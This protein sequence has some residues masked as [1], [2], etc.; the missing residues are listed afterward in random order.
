MSHV[1]R[2]DRLRAAFEPAGVDALVVSQP[3]SRY[4]LSGYA[5]HDLPPRDSAGYLIVTRDKTLLLTDPRT[6]EQA[7][8]E[9]P[10][11][12]IITYSAGNRGPA[13]IA[14]TLGSLGVKRVGF[15]S[16]HLPYAI[17]D[18]VRGDLPSGVAF[19]PV[20]RLIDDLRII[21]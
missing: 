5:G 16:I 19:A 17:W 12:E 15:E 2:I 7:E 9:S 11:Y 1:D 13:S 18:A 3:E 14:A 20:D 8:Q 10:A 6:R 4:Y 21:K